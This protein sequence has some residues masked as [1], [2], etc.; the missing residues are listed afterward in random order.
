MHCTDTCAGEH[1][2][3]SFCHHR[4]IQH[5]TVA[6]TNPT[7]FQDIGKTADF[8]V[9]F[10]KRHNLMTRWMVTFPNDRR[11]MWMFFKMTIKTVGSNIQLTICKPF[12]FKI[13][14]VKIG[15]FNFGKRFNPVNDFCLLRP[16]AFRIVDRLL[17]TCFIFFE[18]GTCSCGKLL[19]H[20]IEFIH[21]AFPSLAMSVDVLFYL[22]VV[23]RFAIH[24]VKCEVA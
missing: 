5:Y 23:S 12:N 14:S 22:Y 18:I 15:V 2:Y 7:L 17:I 24:V 21:L 6:L 19:W 3:S 8:I 1:S 13:I 20:W 16:K 4:H 11:L 10:F 9:Q